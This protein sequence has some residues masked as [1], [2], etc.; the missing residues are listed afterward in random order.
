MHGS[1]RFLD[2][3]VVGV[4]HRSAI[5]T[6]CAQVDALRGRLGDLSWATGSAASVVG[7]KHRH[8]LVVVRRF[9]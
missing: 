2:L 1:F 4:F 9:H 6:K 8:L 3:V 5:I 7:S